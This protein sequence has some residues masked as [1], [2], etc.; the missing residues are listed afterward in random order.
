MQKK[1]IKKS[2]IYESKVILVSNNYYLELHYNAGA[3]VINTC[4]HK[5]SWVLS[6]VCGSNKAQ[7][8]GEITIIS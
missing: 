3:H 7:G 8:D 5:W 1:I 2:L 6:G 4:V